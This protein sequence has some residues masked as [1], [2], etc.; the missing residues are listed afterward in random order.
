MGWGHTDSGS[1][2]RWSS[3]VERVLLVPGFLGFQRLG[4]LPYFVD[5]DTVLQQALADSDGSTDC[6]TA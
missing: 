6:A 5:V 1:V 4:R 3:V 2:L